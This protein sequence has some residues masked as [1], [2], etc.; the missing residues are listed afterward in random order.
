MLP[1]RKRRACTADVGEGI[2]SPPPT[3]RTRRNRTTPRSHN[4]KGFASSPSHAVKRDP[5]AVDITEAEEGVE[6][7]DDADQSDNVDDPMDVDYSPQPSLPGTNAG[8]RKTRNQSRAHPPTKPPARCDVTTALNT[9][10]SDAG[11]CVPNVPNPAADVTK[12][13]SITPNDDLAQAAGQGL[14][15]PALYRPSNLNPMN[16]AIAT[17]ERVSLRESHPTA[18]ASG[19]PPM[20]YRNHLPP[21]T[22]Y[23]MLDPL[24]A[25]HPL[26]LSRRP[27]V[28]V[29]VSVAQCNPVFAVCVPVPPKRCASNALKIAS[30]VFEMAVRPSSMLPQLYFLTFLPCSSK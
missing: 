30:P 17:D 3:K 15:S 20:P 28:D 6:H 13:G 8:R 14:V 24:R 9:R 7:D 16:Q 10:R 18:G 27:H 29:A 23:L 2:L 26:K 19:L 21:V 22:Y 1:S 5:A 12:S 25:N 11:V 4:E